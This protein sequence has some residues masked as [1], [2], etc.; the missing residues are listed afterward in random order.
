MSK[1]FILVPHENDNGC[2][3]F[4]NSLK[5]K[6]DKDNIELAISERPYV[7]YMVISDYEDESGNFTSFNE[8]MR[9]IYEKSQRLKFNYSILYRGREYY[10]KLDRVPNVELI[11]KINRHINF[12]KPEV[13][14]FN[15]DEGNIEYFNIKDVVSFVCKNN[16]YINKLSKIFCG[17]DLVIPSSESETLNK[18]NIN[19][20]NYKRYIYEL[21]F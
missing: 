21:L 20:W 2:D 3:Y 7:L 4:L 12:I 9:K 17:N 5:D 6:L 18:E 14:I 16:K 19:G 11:T 1:W 13:F 15:S 10:N 8:S